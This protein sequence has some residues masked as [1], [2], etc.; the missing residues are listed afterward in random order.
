MEAVG[1]LTGGVAHDFNNLLAVVIG[2]VELL[3]D[4]IGKDDPQ[5]QAVMRASTRGAELTQRLLAF[6]RQQPLHPRPVDLE[7]L[8]EGMTNLLSRTLGETIEIEV[9]SSPNLWAALADSGQVENALLNLAL[10][11]RDAMPGGG[12]LTIETANAKLNRH[13]FA[14]RE[15]ARP[16]DYVVL[17]IRD[18]GHG[19]PPEVLE[20]VFE[21]FFTTK[22]VGEGTGLGLSMVYGFAQQSGGHITIDSAEGRGTIVKLYLPR[23]TAAENAVSEETA[24]SETVP[25]ARG[26]AVL[27]IE[28]DPAVRELTVTV[29]ESL[30]Y[31]VMAARNEKAVSKILATNERIDLVL[32]DV[33]LPGGRSGPDFAAETMSSRPDVKLLFMSGY[34]SEELPPSL[35]DGVMLLNKPFRK[36]ELAIKLREVLD[37]D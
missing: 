5:V 8:V 35:H 27:V 18:T 2:N 24:A 29:L 19:I 1:Q 36:A 9:S 13:D 31:H 14:G 6:S 32:C 22:D 12:T 34:A 33:V 25:R 11:A 26:E 37:G 15:D 17:A 30:G 10:N 28:D 23:A 16:G 7:V 20:H 3:S 4:R 21:P